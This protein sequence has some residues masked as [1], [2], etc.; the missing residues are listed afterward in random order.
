M[1]VNEHHA[2]STPN[3]LLVPYSTHHVP[4][5]HD[6]MSDP[7]LQTATASEPLTLEEEYSMQISWREDNDKLTFIICLPLASRPSTS[8]NP[9][10][11]PSLQAGI[12]DGP[13][14]MIG[15]I[16][17][18]LFPFEADGE[19]DRDET[20]SELPRND[21]GVIG[22][23]ELMIGRRDLQR[24]GF[25]RA[26]LLTFLDH[27]LENWGAI[28]TEYRPDPGHDRTVAKTFSAERGK[29]VMQLAY[30]RAK[31]QESNVGSIALFESVGFVRTSARANYFGE[32]ELRLGAPE[33]G[34]QDQPRAQGTETLVYKEVCSG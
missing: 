20:A 9:Q 3:L 30:L 2:I 21:A 34:W 14:R 17:L 18:F 11:T 22:E 7:A 4:T 25:G 15:D 16:N 6:W 31:I 33:R 10:P 13:E 19:D 27:I 5:Y 23:I 28:Y 8:Q 12:D 26:A 1:K 24:K 29:G 32:V